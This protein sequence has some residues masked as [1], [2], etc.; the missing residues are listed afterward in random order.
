MISI[1]RQ[2]QLDRDAT[3]GPSTVEPS[4]SPDDSGSSFNNRYSENPYDPASYVGKR[5][6]DDDRLQLLSTK[7]NLP[8]SFEYPV[9]SGRRFN[10]RWLAGRPWLHYSV[11]ND[12][13]YCVVCLC[14]CSS[15]EESPFVSTGFNKWKKAVGKKSGYL[16]QHMN[17]ES[18]KIAS[19]KASCFIRTHRTGVNIRTRL[20]EQLAEQQHRTKHGI[21]S[22]IDIIISLG[23]R[24]IPFRGDWDKAKKVEDG[25]FASL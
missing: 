6:S 24:G 11:K 14:F 16:D 2:P 8:D 12:S 3:P 21:L 5:L 9:T 10:P 20:S 1:C 4:G 22:I 19:D 13:A 7:N 25:N 23:Q 17:S 15:V 18:H